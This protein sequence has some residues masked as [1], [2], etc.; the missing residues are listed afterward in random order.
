MINH[1]D[2]IKVEIISVSC[3]AHPPGAAASGS[4]AIRS[5]SRRLVAI[6]RDWRWY[7]AGFQE[8]CKWVGQPP[9]TYRIPRAGFPVGVQ[10]SARINGRGSGMPSPASNIEFPRFKISSPA[11]SPTGTAESTL[12]YARCGRSTLHSAWRPC[13]SVLGP[14]SPSYSSRLLGSVPRRGDF[15][16]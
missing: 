2:Y 8:R 9:P 3:R 7:I 13:A 10:K 16:R 6:A 1:Y 12:R 15:S 14:I 4:V 11:A 5:L